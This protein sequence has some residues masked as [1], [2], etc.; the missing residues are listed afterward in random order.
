MHEVCI[1]ILQEHTENDCRRV[2]KKSP[3]KRQRYCIEG[4]QFSS[5]A[6]LGV[7]GK[8]P[9]AKWDL[10]TEPLRRVDHRHMTATY[11][12]TISWK[13]KLLSVTRFN[14][15]ILFV[16]VFIWD[17]RS[18][19]ENLIPTSKIQPTPQ[20]PRERFLPTQDKVKLTSNL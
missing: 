13:S 4:M 6:A 3:V 16:S 15:T 14:L 7:F 8:T 10:Y 2:E 18:V 17:H 19:D 20:L 11:M 9:E 12:V 5:Q 1:R